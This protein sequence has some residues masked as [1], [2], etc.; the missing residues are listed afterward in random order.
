MLRGLDVSSKDKIVVFQAKGNNFNEQFSALHSNV[1]NAFKKWH[2]AKKVIDDNSFEGDKTVYREQRKEAMQEINNNT[3][4]Y[5][6]KNPNEPLS[7]Y[8]VASLRE[9]DKILQYTDSLGVEALNSV[10]GHILRQNIESMRKYEEEDKANTIAKNEMIGK[11]AP[12]LVLKDKNG[13][14]F[15]LSSLRGK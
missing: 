10:F 12:E 2:D 11:P 3:L 4:N 6:C 5:I 13:N 14:D 9:F 1:L 15:S 8:F 7:A